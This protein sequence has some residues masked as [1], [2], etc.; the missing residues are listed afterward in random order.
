MDDAS[1]AR[2]EAIQALRALAHH[3][4]P[5]MK[6]NGLAGLAALAHLN[7][8][9]CLSKAPR[10]RHVDNMRR[11]LKP[12]RRRRRSASG[13][14]SPLKTLSRQPLPPKRVTSAPHNLARPRRLPTME[15]TSL[16]KTVSCSHRDMPRADN[17]SGTM[18]NFLNTSHGSQSASLNTSMPRRPSRPKLPPLHFGRTKLAPLNDRPKLPLPAATPTCTQ[19]KY[20]MT[21]GMRAHDTVVHDDDDVQRHWSSTRTPIFKRASSHTPNPSRESSFLSTSL[22]PP[23]S[24]PGNFTTPLGRGPPAEIYVASD[25]DDDK[26]LGVD[27]D[28]KEAGEGEVDSLLQ[29]AEDL[30]FDQLIDGDAELSFNLSI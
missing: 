26:D 28:A 7:E 21:P 29:W 13:S 18:R 16:S 15:S 27:G 25:H 3:L 5:G 6:D 14:P 17:S 30:D 9:L 8:G 12:I 23:A 2:E 22:P 19:K 20:A 11:T 1:Q 24:V 10:V 4:I